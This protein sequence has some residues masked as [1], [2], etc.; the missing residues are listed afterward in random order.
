MAVVFSF[1]AFLLIS[2]KKTSSEDMILL[3]FREL[4]NNIHSELLVGMS[5]RNAI[6]MSISMQEYQSNQLNEAVQLLNKSMKF[7]LSEIKAWQEFSKTMNIRYISEFVRVLEITYNYS[8]NIT[9]IIQNT[10]HSISDAIDLTL[11]LSVMIAA[12]RFEFYMMMVLP[13]I[14]LG[15]LS[16]SQY[17]YMSVLYQSTFGRIVMSGVL[18][19]MGIAYIIGK[20]IIKVETI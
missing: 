13:V 12:K 3:E 10:I 16:Y 18:L 19:S 9:E 5:F 15:L 1:I 11:E 7:G 20:E 6:D 17:D 2:R 4:L 14:M 8:G